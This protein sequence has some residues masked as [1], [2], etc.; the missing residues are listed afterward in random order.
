[1]SRYDSKWVHR[2][3]S[4]DGKPFE[5]ESYIDSAQTMLVRVQVQGQWSD[6]EVAPIGPAGDLHLIAEQTAR[7]ILER[8]AL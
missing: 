1:M 8:A 5:M 7:R 2:T 4:H 6:P 3:I